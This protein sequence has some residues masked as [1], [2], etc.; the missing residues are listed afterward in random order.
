MENIKTK[1][2]KTCNQ[3]KSLDDYYYQPTR[4]GARGDC[5]KCHNRKRSGPDRKNI[6]FQGL[7]LEVKDR[8]RSL[9]QDVL[10]GKSPLT[11]AVRTLQNEYPT[12]NFTYG[13]VNAWHLKKQIV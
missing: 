1:I 13:K 4:P 3:E 2:C 8:V 5:K 11:D 10:F 12:H 7:P 6:G 9:Y